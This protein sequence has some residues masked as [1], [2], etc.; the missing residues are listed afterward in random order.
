ML[1]TTGGTKGSGLEPRWRAVLGEAPRSRGFG[2]GAE[3]DRGAGEGGALGK[4]FNKRQK[5][6][7]RKGQQERSSG[8]R[9]DR[10]SF[11]QMITIRAGGDFR[12]RL[13]G[14]ETEAQR[15]SEAQTKVC[16]PPVCA[17]RPVLC[18]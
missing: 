14:E 10:F 8:W 11:G 4:L 6:R 3:T 7:K 12:S 9:S 13:A 1:V 17:F 2:D 5:R 15:G 18:E 16:Q